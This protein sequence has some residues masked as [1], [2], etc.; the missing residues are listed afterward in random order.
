[1]QSCKSFNLC[2]K[3]WPNLLRKLQGKQL[4]LSVIQVP[5]SS[6]YH[7]I[8]SYHCIT[9]RIYYSSSSQNYSGQLNI[10]KLQSNSN[11]Q[12]CRVYGRVTLVGIISSC[13]RRWRS[14]SSTLTPT[15][16]FHKSILRVKCL[17]NAE[18]RAPNF[19]QPGGETYLCRLFLDII[20]FFS[21]F[22]G[23]HM[24]NICES[25]LLNTRQQLLIS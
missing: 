1:M 6:S 24:C 2:I 14:C 9:P 20:S 5:K 3:G 18:G 19:Q 7:I 23:Q 15:T 25:T 22:R 17:K 8:R 16:I 11:R 4:E 10:H 21:G 12:M 13:T